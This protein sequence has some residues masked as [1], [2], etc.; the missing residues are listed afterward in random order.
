MPRTIHTT[1]LIVRMMQLA[2]PHDHKSLMSTV[3]IGRS[4][5]FS[6][7][8]LGRRVSLPET[9][10]PVLLCITLC[11]AFAIQAESISAGQPLAFDSSVFSQP[12]SLSSAS[13]WTSPETIAAAEAAELHRAEAIE[14]QAENELDL[15]NSLT[16]I[17]SASV[18]RHHPNRI[19]SGSFMVPAPSS[20]QQDLTSD[21]YW[22]ISTRHITST[23]CRANLQNPNLHISRL[24]RCG[25]TTPSS[26][27]EY[28]ATFD[29]SRPR[30]I[31]VHGNRR[32]APLAIQRGLDVAR[33]L[34]SNRC[35]HTPMDFVIWSWQSDRETFA[36]T[37]ARI[38]AERTDAQGLYLAWLLHRH[39][40][41]AQPTALIGFSFGGR[42]VTGSLHALAGGTIGRRS[43]S[44][45]PV[46]A[47]NL[48]VGLLA[49]AIQSD[50]LMPHGY[51]RLA[52]QN[53]NRLVL[54]YNQRDAILKNYWLLTRIRGTRALGYTGPTRFAPRYDGSQ[55]PVRSRDCSPTVGKAHSEEEYYKRSCYA[56]REMASLLTSSLQID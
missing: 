42:I 4:S 36:I 1:R 35:A 49:P 8:L 13:D 12:L 45:E 21:R 33:E 56:G 5:G 17:P 27:D 34:E 46:Q 18:P 7:R 6:I 20:L 51:H 38:K 11:S 54:L 52:T 50:W 3:V 2:H 53:M 26:L 37:D 16:S 32:S 10:A 24:N 25:Q 19:P 40:E 15:S 30:V 14:I 29:P 44:E 48:D 43:L 28:I 39:V 23:A 41:A 9:I 31:Y 55:L 22:L 47:A